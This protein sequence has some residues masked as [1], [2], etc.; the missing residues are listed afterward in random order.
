MRGVIGW[1]ADADRFNWRPLIVNYQ[2][3]PPAGESDVRGLRPFTRERVRGPPPRERYT[4]RRVVPRAR[5]S[6]RGGAAHVGLQRYNTRGRCAYVIPYVRLRHRQRN[7]K[8][9]QRIRAS[10]RGGLHYLL[11]A[12]RRRA[13]TIRTYARARA[14]ARIRTPRHTGCIVNN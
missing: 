6:E 3:Y 12:Y 1:P 7:V 8:R 14:R 5:S 11:D 4:D 13:C 9:D 10:A 2:W